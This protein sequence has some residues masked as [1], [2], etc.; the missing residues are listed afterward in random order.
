MV[1][2]ILQSNKQCVPLVRSRIRKAKWCC[3][4]SDAFR[5]LS[6]PFTT[7][8]NER[9]PKKTQT[10]TSM[11]TAYSDLAK[12]KLSA[13]VVTTAAAGFVATGQPI[14]TTEFAYCLT[15]TALCS[16]S[17][18]A[19]NQIF[20]I[21][22][23]SRM[24]R[25]QTRPLVT[26]VLSRTEATT[27][28][29]LWGVSGTAL[30][31]CTDPVTTALGVGNILLYSGLYTYLKP[32]S[33]VNTWVG[34]VVGAVPPLVS[35]LSV[36]MSLYDSSDRYIS[37]SSDY[38]HSRWDIQRLRAVLSMPRPCFWEPRCM[39]GKCHIFSLSP[40]CIGSTMPAAGSRCS[41]VSI[42]IKQPN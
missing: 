41:P 39:F 34:A 24:K 29:V 18:A 8:E 14:W 27:A 23:D 7:S 5:M 40:T 21:D 42:Q 37:H 28:A 9:S 31:S 22:R 13:L 33:V 30:L 32:R 17:A 19:F 10:K 35:I 1:S 2:I 26:A 3:G 20:E 16:S 4:G 6:T 25:T 12:F 38:C 15:G 36:G 11:L